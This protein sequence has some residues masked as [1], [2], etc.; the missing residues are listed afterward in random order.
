VE[1]FDT[2]LQDRLIHLLDFLGCGKNK[3]QFAKKV[4]L[5]P[6]TVMKIYHRKCLP[7]LRLMARIAAQYP[8]INYNWLLTGQGKM[9]TE[10]VGEEQETTEEQQIIHYLQEL[11]EKDATIIELQSELNELSN[12]LIKYLEQQIRSNF[13]E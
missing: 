1:D 10:K 11:K 13:K 7:T 4:G 9:I 2:L 5:N 6:H 8:R 3:S 12:K